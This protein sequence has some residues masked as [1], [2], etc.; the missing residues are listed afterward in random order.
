M[1]AGLHLDVSPHYAKI[2]IT[3]S[4]AGGRSTKYNRKLYATPKSC[5]G[6][7]FCEQGMPSSM[8]LSGGRLTTSHD[9]A[10]YTCI[11]MNA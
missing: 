10:P 5:L 7:L 9:F 1:E 6:F 2:A 3:R 11:Y 8:F 4:L